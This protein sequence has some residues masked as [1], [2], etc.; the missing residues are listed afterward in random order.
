MNQFSHPLDKTP[1]IYFIMNQFSHPLDNKTPV[2]YFIGVKHTQ[3]HRIKLCSIAAVQL[4][5]NGQSIK[6]KHIYKFRKN[7]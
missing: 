6:H 1:V 2:I 7:M 5:P 3:S 4:L